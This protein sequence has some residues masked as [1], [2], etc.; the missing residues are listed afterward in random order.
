[1]HKIYKFLF[2]FDCTTSSLQ[3]QRGLLEYELVK[4]NVAV[5]RQSY[6]YIIIM[7][8]ELTLEYSLSY[9]WVVF[10]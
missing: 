3:I 1:M 2:F 5:R 4:P 10:E 6:Y 7:W 8:M 9:K